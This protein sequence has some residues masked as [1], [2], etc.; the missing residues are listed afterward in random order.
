MRIITRVTSYIRH[1]THNTQTSLS[2]SNIF[3]YVDMGLSH[4]LLKS[5][6]MI[7][8]ETTYTKYTRRT[9]FD[10]IECQV[11]DLTC[12]NCVDIC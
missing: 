5:W 9:D 11:V 1:V 12:P 8:E 3:L 2:S 7:S 4:K 6:H 10:D